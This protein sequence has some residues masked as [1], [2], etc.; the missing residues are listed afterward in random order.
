M[1]YSKVFDQGQ[2]VAKMLRDAVPPREMAQ[3][4]VAPARGAKRLVSE[5]EMLPGGTRRYVGAH[6]VDADIFDGMCR[7]AYARHIKA[8]GS[9]EGFVPPFTPGQMAMARRYR[10]LTERHSAGG[11]KCASLEARG[12]GGAGQGGEFIDAFVAEGRELAAMHRNI[13]SG[14]SMAVRRIRPSKRGSKAAILNRCLVD[15]VCLGGSDLSAV[16]RAHGWACKGD[17]RDAL[18]AALCVSL[19]RMQGYRDRDLK[20]GD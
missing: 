13:G 16:L 1:T 20:K 18:R 3:A 12:G 6:W 14:Q 19:D 7:T 10:D 17:H 5:Y 8:G 15:M 9:P 2:A 11:M 4:P